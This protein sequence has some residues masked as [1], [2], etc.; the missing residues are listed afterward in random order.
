MAPYSWPQLTD[1]VTV[2]LP[3]PAQERL[4]GECVCVY[5]FVRASK[6]VHAQQ[7]PVEVNQW[8]LMM[9]LFCTVC[10]ACVCVCVC[11][12]VCW[13]RACSIWLRRP[14]SGYRLIWVCHQ[15]NPDDN[16]RSCWGGLG[17]WLAH[18][19]T[20]THTHT[21]T[22]WEMVYSPITQPA[23]VLEGGSKSL[24]CIVHNISSVTLS[25]SLLAHHLYTV[26]QLTALCFHEKTV[27]LHFISLS[28]VSLFCLKGLIGLQVII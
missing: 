13:G 17:W 10:L 27:Q 26:F 9:F 28:R 1:L 12:C 6:P 23:S 24:D 20:H 16:G 21:H 4:C 15:Q 5:M 25:L 3:P 7:C 22:G 14:S 11:V 18:K 19:H 8:S 2:W